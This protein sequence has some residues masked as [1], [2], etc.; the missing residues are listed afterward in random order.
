MQSPHKRSFAAEELKRRH[1]KKPW[2][3]VVVGIA[4]VLVV[5]GGYMLYRRSAKQSQVDTQQISSIAVLPFRD[6]SPE[7]DQE[8]F[9]DGMAES[10][11][12]ALTHVGTLKVSAQTSSFAFKG[13]ETGIKDIGSQFG[14][15]SVLEGSIIKS[16]S[17]LTITAQLIKVDDGFHI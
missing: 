3:W 2:L 4:V 15:E 7:K 5:I 14:V 10:I 16:G 8:W 1:Q 17:R 9:C 13:K 12:N 11:L 6:M